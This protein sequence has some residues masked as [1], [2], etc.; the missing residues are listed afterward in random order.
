MNNEARSIETDFVVLSPDKHA[1]IEHFDASLYERLDKN[2]QGFSG[3]EL[4][5][6]YEFDKDWSSWEIHPHGDEIVI[7][8]SGE[9]T[10]VLQLENEEKSVSLNTAGTYLIVPKNIWHTA[11]THVKTKMLFITPGQG[12]QHKSV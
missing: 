2:Y 9:V 7:L 12:T 4:I 5:S 11:K 8:L 10:F 6:C 3:H 1:T